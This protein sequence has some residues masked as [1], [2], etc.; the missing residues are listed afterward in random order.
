[1]LRVKLPF[2]TCDNEMIIIVII[3]TVKTFTGFDMMEFFDI[4]CEASRTDPFT[5]AKTIDIKVCFY[6]NYYCIRTSVDW[7]VG[8][9]VGAGWLTG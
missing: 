6:F 7:L 1:M 2:L 3:V 8:S 4:V 9:L 5:T